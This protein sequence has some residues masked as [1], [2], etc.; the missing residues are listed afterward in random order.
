MDRNRNRLSI[1]VAKLYYRSEYSQQRIAE[2]MGIS[3]P[4]VSRLLQHAKDMGYVKIQI[5]DPVEDMG[6][7]ER[8]LAARYALN[9]VRVVSSTINDEEEIKKY[10]GIKTAEYID[11][12]VRDGDIIGV[13]WGT[14]LYNVSNSLI[15]RQLKGSQIVQLEGGVT[16]AN[17]ETFANDIL[18]RFARNYGTIAQHLPLPVIFDSSAVKEMVYQDRH[19]NRVLELG[20]HAN[21]AVFSVGTV[22][23]S[24]LFFRLGYTDAEEKTRIQ[25][26]AV[27]DICSRFFDAAG[28]ICNPQLDDRTVGIRL[29]DLTAKEHSI[30]ASGGE[31]KLQAIHA[32]LIGGY[33]N[34]F[35]TDQFTARA[36][37][38]IAQE[39]EE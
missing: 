27:G 2:E 1:T 38:D 36:L 33:A 34:T 29:Q 23:N 17:G 15:P 12:I 39:D 24:A 32:A 5:F 14:T 10:I 11:T 7:M 6:Q 25:K 31:A 8:R 22:R 3:R 26:E 19:I 9:E 20:R 28:H 16:H 4:S 37:L 18:E 21:I 13:G 35:I 30:L